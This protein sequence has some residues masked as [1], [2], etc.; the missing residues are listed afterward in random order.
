MG[1]H[2]W[3]LAGCCEIQASSHA[4]YL[5]N[6]LWEPMRL[7]GVCLMGSGLDLR[8]RFSRK[9]ARTP[10]GRVRGVIVGYA[11]PAPGGNMRKR[12]GSHGVRWE[13]LRDVIGCRSG[14]PWHAMVHCRGPTGAHRSSH[15]ISPNNTT[16]CNNRCVGLF[17]I[18]F[19]TFFSPGLIY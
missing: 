12:M 7:R 11:N 6:S 3:N 14:I 16:M 19:F 9:F 13:I 1:S 8:L 15:G 4:I 17:R 2:L 10:H 18:R 5:G